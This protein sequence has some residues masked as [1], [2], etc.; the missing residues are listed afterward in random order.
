MKLWII[1]TAPAWEKAQQ[2][3][4]LKGDGRRVDRFYKPSYEWLMGQMRERVPQYKG[5]YP[6]WAYAS[7]KPDL[8]RR[9]FTRGTPGVRLEFVA[10]ADEVLISDFDAWHMVLNGIYCALTEQEDEEFYKNNGSYSMW[11]HGNKDPKKVAQI[12]KSW[13][14]IFDVEALAATPEWEGSQTLQATLGQITLDQVVQVT[15]FISR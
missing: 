13:E 8:R 10:E 2:T 5:G 3:G 12:T 6:I 9:Q 14:R 1:Q 15:P 4:I 7:D 11:F